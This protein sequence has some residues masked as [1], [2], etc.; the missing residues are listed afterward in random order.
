MN[1]FQSPRSSSYTIAI[2]SSSLILFT[3]FFTYVISVVE[4]A[5]QLPLLQLN[6]PLALILANLTLYTFKFKNNL[7]AS[8]VIFAILSV[9]LYYVLSKTYDATWDGQWYHQD[10]ILKLSEGWNPFYSN[11]N[12]SLSIS[13]SDFW[14]HHYPQASWIVQA[15]IFQLGGSIQATKLLHLILSIACFGIA[16]VVLLDLL[17]INAFVS[18]LFSIC[19]AFNPITYSQ[20][21]SFYVD[22]QTAMGLSIYI[23]LL[24]HLIYKPSRLYYLLLSAIFIYIA[25]IKF[26]N[27]VYLSVFNLFFYGL[28]NYKQKFE[29]VK[30]NTLFF[31]ALY[32]V[33]IVCIGYSSYTRN[34]LENGNPFYPL[35]GKNNI[36]EI[37]KNI[38]L[39]ANF[40]NQNRFEN[41]I[42]ASFAY[43]EYARSPDT[44]RFRMPFT[45][46]DYKNF[47]RVDNE[48]SGF[49]ARWSEILLISLLGLVVLLF[50]LKG[51]KRVGFIL[52]IVG[53]LSSVFINEQCFVARYVPQMWIFPIIII[54]FCFTFPSI[55]LRAYALG[56]SLFLL[57]NTYNIIEVQYY[58]QVEVRNHINLEID[59]LRTYSKPISV[60]CKY[61][62]V[63]NKLKEKNI[64]YIELQEDGP[65]QKVQFNHTFEENYYIQQ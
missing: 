5:L 18:L 60:K 53:L 33:G 28:I 56:L 43:P 65:G 42:D 49:G 14:I 55:L 25:N 21:F 16:Y 20:F 37:V 10:A 59:Y 64:P 46:V 41:F 44:S 17:P 61:R 36:G 26:T 22:G 51:Q 30:R 48:L 3:I 4:L 38:P 6:I 40:I 9:V 32:L 57:Y 54:I 39:S 1:T 47:Y 35:L 12:P 34:S 13:E 52:L 62:S 23:L 11:S 2:N 50:A 58:Y 45:E 27:V 31:I 7:I 8:N 29:V 24:I 15:N 19:I 63:I